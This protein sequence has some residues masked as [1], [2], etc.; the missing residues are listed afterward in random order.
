MAE[1]PWTYGGIASTGRE[2]PASEKPRTL[3]MAPT[4]MASRSTGNS[5]MMNRPIASEAATSSRT[6]RNI[7]QSEPRMGY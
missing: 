7:H 3:M 4:E 5:P 1:K 2:K 6:S